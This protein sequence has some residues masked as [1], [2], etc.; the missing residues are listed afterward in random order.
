VEGD[1]SMSKLI[2]T[3]DEAFRIDGRLYNFDALCTDVK[4]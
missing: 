1:V 4:T 2:S 3:K